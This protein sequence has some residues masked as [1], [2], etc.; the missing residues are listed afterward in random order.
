M[1][2][3]EVTNVFDDEVV[4]VRGDS[5][6]DV[7]SKLEIPENLINVKEVSGD[8]ISEDQYLV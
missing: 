2:T 6:A 8:G 7:Q 5:V 3:Y 1:K 4:Y